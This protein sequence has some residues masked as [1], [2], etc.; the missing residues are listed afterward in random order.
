MAQLI[1]VV[2]ITLD[3]GK[4]LDVKGIIELVKGFTNPWKCRKCGCGPLFPH[5]GTCMCGECL[6]TTNFKN[7]EEKD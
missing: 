4:P 2:S 1:G 6:W 5:T 7:E 3:E